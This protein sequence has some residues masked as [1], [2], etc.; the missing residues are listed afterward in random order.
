LCGAAL[1]AD[2]AGALGLSENQL[3]I[4]TVD[5]TAPAEGTLELLG[6]FGFLPPG[7]QAVAG[8][9]NPG[10]VV[11]LVRAMLT[12]RQVFS[13]GGIVSGSEPQVGGGT[14]C[15]ITGTGYLPASERIPGPDEFFPFVWEWFF[16]DVGDPGLLVPG[17]VA[18]FV[19]ELLAA[20]AGQRDRVL[21]HR[22]RPAALP[23]R[24]LPAARLGDRAGRAA[25]GARPDGPSGPARRTHGRCAGSVRGWQK[26][27]V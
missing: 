4:L 17:E 14:F 16:D 19:G 26:M 22:P 25:S 6:L 7:S 18:P 12:A 9:F 21:R 8:G 24:G 10:E 3:A 11:L 1:R 5:N 20:R 2:D 13:I 15:C 27:H 23:S